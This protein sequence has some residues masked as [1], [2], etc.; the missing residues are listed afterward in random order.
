MT[1]TPSETYALTETFSKVFKTGFSQWYE[2]CKSKG[3]EIA[4]SICPVL[5]ATTDTG[6]TF[7][8]KVTVVEKG[9]NAKLSDIIRCTD[10]RASSK[11]LVNGESFWV[12]I[13][14]GRALTDVVF[15]LD[16]MYVRQLVG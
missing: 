15:E 2:S 16:D 10:A 6:Y 14:T 7:R 13:D 1:K 11:F 4:I 8:T 3:A 5:T 9:A 12:D